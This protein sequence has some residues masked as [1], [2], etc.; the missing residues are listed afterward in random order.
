MRVDGP[1]WS[2][3]FKKEGCSEDF[4]RELLIGWLVC[5]VQLGKMS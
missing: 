4:P 5:V 2:V 3:W 1:A